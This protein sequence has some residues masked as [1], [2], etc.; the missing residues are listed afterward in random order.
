[1][2]RCAFLTLL[3]FA[4]IVSAHGQWKLQD[5]HTTADLRGVH[6][7]GRGIVWVSGSHG[8]VSL[9]LRT[10]DGGG[11][12]QH[13]V[14]PPAAEELDFRAIQAFDE[15]TAL[16]MSSGPG[17]QSRLYKTTDGCQT[18]RLVFSNP[19]KDDM[20]DALR[21]GDKSDGGVLIGQPV[22]GKFAIY[23]THDSGDTWAAWGNSSYHAKSA[24]RVRQAPAK[25]GE[26]IFTSG[27]SAVDLIGRN[28]FAFVTGGLGGPRVLLTDPRDPFDNGVTWNFAVTRLPFPS[29]QDGGAFSIADRPVNTYGGTDFMVVGGNSLSPNLM[30]SCVFLPH[31]EERYLGK[32]LVLGRE[33]QKVVQSRTPPHGWR[34]SVAYDNKS[35]V[36]LAVGPNGTEIS[37]NDGLDWS[38]LKPTQQEASD[39]DQHWYS[40]S[41]PF[42]VGDHGRIGLLETALRR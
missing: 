39:A 20:W 22:D 38:A 40:L 7:L 24:E 37:T 14:T 21:I 17:D 35:N 31:R 2:I 12:W 42:A 11:N 10:T 16:V 3:A 26:I 15:N 33:Q 5:G 27:N 4:C 8:T 29:T 28:Q 19:S 32:L 9:W 41:L 13:C 30:G 1:M 34:S 25:K 6:A 23:E 18:W 36:W